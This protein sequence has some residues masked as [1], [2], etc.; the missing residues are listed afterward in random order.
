VLPNCVL[1]SRNARVVHES[2]TDLSRTFGYVASLR[3]VKIIW[4]IRLTQQIN[5]EVF[6]LMHQLLIEPLLPTIKVLAGHPI[7]DHPRE[8][9]AG[10]IVPI[11]KV[12]CPFS[13]P[14]FCGS[15]DSEAR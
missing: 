2:Q 13:I 6:C 14:P 11:D 15:S 10:D 1:P 8:G 9:S 12:E 4:Q 5:P 7:S 3:H